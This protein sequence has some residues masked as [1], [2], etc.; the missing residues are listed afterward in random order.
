MVRRWAH[1][2]PEELLPDGEGG[3]GDVLVAGAGGGH[4]GG[5]HRALLPPQELQGVEA[6]PHV[7]LGAL[8]QRRQRLQ[9]FGSEFE[10]RVFEQVSRACN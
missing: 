6:A 10:S 7:A 9:G 4:I 8:R 5:A 3:G 1:P 2:L